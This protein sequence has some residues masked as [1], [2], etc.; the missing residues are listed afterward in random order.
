MIAAGLKTDPRKRELLYVPYRPPACYRPALLDGCCTRILHRRP[1]PD[2]SAQS[3]QMCKIMVCWFRASRYAQVRSLSRSGRTGLHST[4]RMLALGCCHRARAIA[5]LLLLLRFCAT[6][7]YLVALR[8]SRCI[9]FHVFVA[10][11][12]ASL[13][14]CATYIHEGPCGSAQRDGRWAT[15]PAV[16]STVAPLAAR[17]MVIVLA[18]TGCR[19]RVPVQPVTGV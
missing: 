5:P 14:A 11:A 2:V 18:Q 16:G 1:Q 8:S 9:T 13:S 7:L 15:Y 12:Q 4:A 3:S 19:D 6:K 10:Y 17:R